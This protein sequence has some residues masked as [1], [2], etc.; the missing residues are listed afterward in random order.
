M[1]RRRGRCSA[2][3]PYVAHEFAVHT[4]PVASTPGP[5]GPERATP[6]RETGTVGAL[7]GC[8]WREK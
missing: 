6:G 1:A 2:I 5:N 8:I 7:W 4:A 3:S